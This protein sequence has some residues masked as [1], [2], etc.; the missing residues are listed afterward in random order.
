MTASQSAFDIECSADVRSRGIDRAKAI[1]AENTIV[2]W[3]DI[4]A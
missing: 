3:D 1:L 4:I 2:A